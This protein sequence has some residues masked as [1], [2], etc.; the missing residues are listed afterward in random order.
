MKIAAVG[1]GLKIVLEIHDVYKIFRP[2]IQTKL[3][4]LNGNTILVI[5]N[6]EIVIVSK[7]KLD[8]KGKWIKYEIVLNSS[9][10]LKYVFHHFVDNVC[11]NELKYS[12]IQSSRLLPNRVR[13]E[14]FTFRVP[15]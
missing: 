6:I 8:P 15:I 4:I 2:E 5:I 7:S 12:I 14:H 11:F 3:L 13:N 9:I 1:A 10:G